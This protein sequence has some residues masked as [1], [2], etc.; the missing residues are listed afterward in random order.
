MLSTGVGSALLARCSG[1]ENHRGGGAA[2]RG[3][4]GAV[5]LGSP[6]PREFQ[7][8]A[9]PR[10]AV[11]AGAESCILRD[12]RTHA[13]GI[14]NATQPGSNHAARASLSAQL[15]SLTGAETPRKD[16]ERDTGESPAPS[17][18]LCGARGRPGGDGAAIVLGQETGAS[19]RR[20]RGARGGGGAA[21]PPPPRAEPNRPL[22]S[23]EQVI[24]REQRP[25]TAG[26]R[27]LA[28][29]L[30]GHS[31][32]RGGGRSG[33]PPLP[34]P[35]HVS[36]T[37]DGQ[38]CPAPCCGSGQSERAGRG[39]PRYSNQPHGKVASRNVTRGRGRETGRPGPGAN[40]CGEAGHGWPV[41]TPPPYQRPRWA[42]PTAIC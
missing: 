35:G 23:N 39:R 12:L 10:P 6:S 30:S 27:A 20:D 25:I 41:G 17:P 19:P 15:R 38:G 3:P 7:E 31:R 24:D 5:R 4:A 9:L 13:P 42:W 40:P 28:P 14:T 21:P 16:G 11:A 2:A 8:S 22:R 36:H 18:P 29:A 32:A 26:G 37:P 33:A 34:S 1:R